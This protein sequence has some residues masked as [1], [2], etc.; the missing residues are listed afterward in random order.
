MSDLKIPLPI[1]GFIHDETIAEKDA[2]IAELERQVE[3]LCSKAENMECIDPEA[4]SFGCRES[5]S[6]CWR[7]W[8]AKK[9]AESIE[10]TKGTKQ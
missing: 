1:P 7:D 2:R 9:A 5:C 10:T 6:D 3:I 4:T 8:S